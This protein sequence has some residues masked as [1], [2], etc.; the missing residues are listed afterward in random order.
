MLNRYIDKI[1]PPLLQHRLNF[2]FS[3][4]NLAGF[5]RLTPLSINIGD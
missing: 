1:Y 4:D 2:L 3:S 5:S